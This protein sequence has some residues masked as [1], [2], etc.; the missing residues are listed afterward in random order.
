MSW[1]QSLFVKCVLRYDPREDG[2]ERP[3]RVQARARIIASCKC[4]L[5]YRD[6]ISTEMERETFCM[7]ARDATMHGC[8]CEPSLAQVYQTLFLFINIGWNIAGLVWVRAHA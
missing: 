7:C 1:C 5:V 3:L 2:A 6:N 8:L 4:S